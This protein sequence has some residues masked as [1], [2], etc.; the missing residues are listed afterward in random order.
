MLED[1]QDHLTEK[2]TELKSPTRK[3]DI[4]LQKQLQGD[5]ANEDKS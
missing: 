5:V 2:L 1:A 4:S 3:G